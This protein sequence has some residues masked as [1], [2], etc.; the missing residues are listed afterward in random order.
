ARRSW[1]RENT[2]NSTSACS[3]FAGSCCPRVCALAP[4]VFDIDAAR[5][6]VL[7]IAHPFLLTGARRGA[8][9]RHVHEK[10]KLIRVFGEQNLRLPQQPLGADLP[11]RSARRIPEGC[12]LDDGRLVPMPLNEIAQVT[13]PGAAEDAAQTTSRAK[14]LE[15]VVAP[16]QPDQR[17]DLLR[18]GAW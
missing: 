13:N 7:N 2:S 8:H 4:P 9:P 15:V 1:R 14:R 6:G 5:D 11:F 10:I 12:R 18:L 3:F 16:Q 17:G